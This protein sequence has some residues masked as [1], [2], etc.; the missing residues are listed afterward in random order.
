VDEAVLQGAKILIG[1]DFDE[2]SSLM[3][4]KI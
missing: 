1:G 4:P 3:S 2:S